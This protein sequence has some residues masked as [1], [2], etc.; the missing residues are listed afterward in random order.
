MLNLEDHAKPALLGGASLIEIA[1][2][3]ARQFVNALEK[4]EIVLV[5]GAGA[6]ATSTNSKGQCVRQSGSLAALLSSEAGLPYNGEDLPDVIGAVVGPRISAVQ[7]HRMLAAEYTKITPSPELADLLGYTWRRLYTWNV[8]DLVENIHN[9]VQRRR[10]FNGM[11]DKVVAHEGLSYLSVIH[12]HGE[13]LKPEHG[14]IFSVS[15]YNARLNS[16]THDWYREAVADYVAYTPLFVGSKLKE[17]ILSAELDRARPNPDAGLGRAFL[18]TP[19]EFSPV[20][21]ANLSARNFCVLRA[22]LEELVSWLKSRIERKVT[23]VDV[24]LKVNAFARELSEKLDV[25]KADVDAV[26]TVV[27]RTWA[28]TKRDADALQKSERQKLGRS[29][30]EGT[31]PTWVIAATDIPVR[32]KD[33]DRLYVEINESISRRDRLFVVYGQSGSGKTTAILQSILRNLN[34]HPDRPV[35]EI[36]SDT[37]SLKAALGLIA[38]IHRFRTRCYIHPRHVCLCRLNA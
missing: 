15:E 14:F 22:T 28:N 34:E 17:P 27:L 31:A 21:M 29:F 4:G 9:G 37:P 1:D 19:D 20:M 6:S 24:A 38:R 2:A 13:A 33:T 35:Y 12:L 8:D 11:K 25:T 7:F 18:V 32:L 30:L 3:D 5:L 23:P 10:Y 16:N 26:R 36:G